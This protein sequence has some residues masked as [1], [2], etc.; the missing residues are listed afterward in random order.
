[1][2]GAIAALK[3]NP[4]KNLE[5]EVTITAITFDARDKEPCVLRGVSSAVMILQMDKYYESS[6]LRLAP[7]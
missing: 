4:A 2:T 5:R 6:E 3:K 1:M 7:Q